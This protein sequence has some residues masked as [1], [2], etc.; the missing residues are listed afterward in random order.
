MLPLIQLQDPTAFDHTFWGPL[1]NEARATAAILAN[2][3]SGG[4]GDGGS[5]A[6]ATESQWG[7]AQALLDETE[8]I[9]VG[10]SVVVCL[11]E[12]LNP[13][14][15]QR[16]PLNPSGRQPAVKEMQAFG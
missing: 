4:A 9:E 6:A 16:W 1:V 12:P 13:C 11:C 3:N 7:D 5:A 2:I 8:D 10:F 15:T 14:L